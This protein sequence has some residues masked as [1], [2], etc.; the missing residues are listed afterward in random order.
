MLEWR[1]DLASGPDALAG[2]TERAHRG[3]PLLGKERGASGPQDACFLA[4][5]CAEGAAEDR[6]VVIADRS[7]HAELR[8]RG[9]GR[10]E[11]SAETNF[12]DSKLTASSREVVQRQSRRYLEGSRLACLGRQ[13]R[14]QVAEAVQFGGEVGIGNGGAVDAD[15]LAVALQVRLGVQPTTDARGGKD[16]REHG[17]RRAFA[18]GARHQ[19]DAKL[20]IGR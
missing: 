19:G 9:I 1:Y 11:P 4:R 17:A 12:D 18:L 8:F 5:D 14:S 6:G 13:P 16:G 2:C 3:G 10:V 15:S 20:A 7:D